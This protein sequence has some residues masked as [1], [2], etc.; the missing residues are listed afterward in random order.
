MR[1]IRDQEDCC[2]TLSRKNKRDPNRPSDVKT[3]QLGMLG[4]EAVAAVSPASNPQHEQ[5]SEP[6]AC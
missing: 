1:T 4:S 5:S 6:S 3:V 2:Y